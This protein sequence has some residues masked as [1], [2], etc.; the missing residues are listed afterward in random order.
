MSL[1]D[2]YSF[3]FF[4]NPAY[5][6]IIEPLESATSPNLYTG[7]DWGEFRRLRADGDYADVGKEVQIA[8]YR[9]PAAE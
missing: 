7:I 8:D 5:G 4:Y 2:R 3:P 1:T 9:V 6:A